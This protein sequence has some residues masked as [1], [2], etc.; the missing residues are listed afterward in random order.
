MSQVSVKQ[1]I[2]WIFY[3]ISE[4]GLDVFLMISPLK[5]SSKGN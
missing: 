5:F 4:R 3:I 2:L 1:Y